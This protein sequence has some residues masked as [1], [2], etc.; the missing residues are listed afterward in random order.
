MWY[1]VSVERGKTP[2]AKGETTMTYEAYVVTKDNPVD[3]SA[4]VYHDG[5]FATMEE[6]I[7]RMDEMVDE[8]LHETDEYVVE[9]GIRSIEDNHSYT[10]DELVM[11]RDEL[12][13]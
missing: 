5:D 12:K 2:N 13:C 1:D 3:Y 8:I 4:Y 7:K 10:G 6:A 11:V 9:R